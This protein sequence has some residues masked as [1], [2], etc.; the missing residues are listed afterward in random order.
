MRAPKH[1][2]TK[3]IFYKADGN[4]TKPWSVS[5]KLRCTEAAAL[6]I[7]T[8][9]LVYKVRESTIKLASAKNVLCDQ[10][11]FHEAIECY[12]K[13]TTMIGPTSEC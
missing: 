11:Q 13:A 1:I 2:I 10:M 3:E 5:T 6:P 9:A 4:T 7:I 8:K 12:N